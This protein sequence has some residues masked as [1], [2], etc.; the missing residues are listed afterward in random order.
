[1]GFVIILLMVLSVVMLLLRYSMWLSVF[2]SGFNLCVENSMVM[3]SL[4]CMLCMSLMMLCWWFGLRLIS[5]LLS[6]SSFGLL[7]RY[8]VSSSCCCL[9]FD[10][11]DS[12]WCV[13]DGLLMRLSM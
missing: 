4:C 5:G 13:S 9:L 10:S 11:L 12:G 3:L 2:S 1:M 7:S 8:C 6:S